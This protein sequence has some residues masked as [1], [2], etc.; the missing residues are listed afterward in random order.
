MNL[1]P[2]EKGEYPQFPL[3]SF[4]ANLALMCTIELLFSLT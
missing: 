3:L 4:Y 1:H 2:K